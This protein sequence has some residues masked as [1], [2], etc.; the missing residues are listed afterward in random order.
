MTLYITYQ[1]YKEVHKFLTGS[2]NHKTAIMNDI[3]NL[4]KC[5]EEL[6]HDIDLIHLTIEKDSEVSMMV[7]EIA[8]STICTVNELTSHGLLGHIDD[9]V[10]NKAYREQKKIERAVCL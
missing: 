1:G 4:Y 9:T 3:T 2:E 6:D 5:L 7:E 8:Q 10:S